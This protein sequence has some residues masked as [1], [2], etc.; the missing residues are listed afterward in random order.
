MYSCRS[1][2]IALIAILTFCSAALAQAPKP[3]DEPPP[4]LEGTAQAALLATTGNASA[5]AL[6]FGGQ[7]IWRPMPWS[8][9]AKATFAQTETDDVLSARS[10]VA[11]ARV[12]RFLTTRTSLFG[13]YH[14]LRDLFAGVE[15]R[16]TVAGGLAYRLIQG[17]PHRLTIDGALGF[18]HESR[19]EE[20]SENVAIVAGGVAYDWEIS[21]TS[22]LTE[23]LRYVQGLESLDN[24]KLDQSIALTAA[25]TSIF[26][27]KIANL[28][29]YA[30]EPVP[31]FESTDTVTSVA[32]VWTI[33]RPGP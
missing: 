27:L 9:R 19:V 4:R 24:W 2:T 22:K 29:R 14:F 17:P 21:A 13:Q 18:E 15:Q 5:Q 26:S 3:S 8:L 25:I 33:K 12:D 7:F 20:E 32:L 11:G 16:S 28:V 23:E 6:G 10:T 1:A 30:N 31:G